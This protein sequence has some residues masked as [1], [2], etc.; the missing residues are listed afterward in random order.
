MICPNHYALTVETERR[1]AAYLAEAEREWLAHHAEENGCAP[2][3]RWSNWPALAAVVGALALLLAAGG[4]TAEE[5]PETSP[6]QK[7]REAAN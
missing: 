6:V 5:S 2:R 7:V 3:R 1:H 4:A